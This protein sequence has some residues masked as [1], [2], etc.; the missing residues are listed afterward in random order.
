MDDK[1]FSE[2]MN[3]IREGSWWKR[4]DDDAVGVILEIRDDNSNNLIVRWT[5]PSFEGSRAGEYD[6]YEF[7]RKWVP[8]ESHPDDIPVKVDS[9]W[10]SNKT[11]DIVKVL[12][13]PDASYPSVHYI[14]LND[15][16]GDQMML[17]VDKTVFIT[18]H[19][20]LRDN[21]NG[22]L[23]RHNKNPNTYLKVIE[24]TKKP[25][26]MGAIDYVKYR[27]IKGD[28]IEDGHV[29]LIVT[30]HSCCHLLS[31]DPEKE[32]TVP[33]DSVRTIKAED[34]ETKR[35][36][37]KYHKIAKELRDLAKERDITIGSIW[38]G[39]KG[40]EEYNKG[41]LIKVVHITGNLISWRYLANA[42]G[43]HDIELNRYGTKTTCNSS[44]LYCFEKVQ[45]ND[46][47]AIY[48]P[49]DRVH[50][51]KENPGKYQM[52]KVVETNTSTTPGGSFICGTIKYITTPVS[53]SV[54][55][56]NL[57]DFHSE[58]ELVSLNPAEEFCVDV[59]DPNYSRKHIDPNK[60]ESKMD[61]SKETYLKTD[62]DKLEDF[63]TGAKREDKTGKGRYD[64]IPGDIMSE[65][66]DFAWTT[67]F[68]NGT[69]TCS[70]TDVSK[71]AYFDAWTNV[72]LYYDFMF[73]VVS[74]FFVPSID[75][76]ECEDDNGEVSYEITWDG[77]RAGLYNMR[78]ALAKHY[79]AGAVVHGVDNWKKGLPIYGSERGGCFLDSMR[80]HIDQALQGKDDEPH[81][82]AA[83]WNAFG[84]VW[85]LKNKST[86]T[87][88]SSE[89]KPEMDVKSKDC[90]GEF[91]TLPSG[92][93][94]RI[95]KF[96]KNESLHLMT[97]DERDISFLRGLHLNDDVIDS[98][99]ES[100]IIV[101]NAGDASKNMKADK[102][103]DKI[104]DAPTVSYSVLKANVSNCVE[105]LS[106]MLVDNKSTDLKFETHEAYINLYMICVFLNSV[107]SWFQENDKA[108]VCIEH[109]ISGIYNLINTNISSVR[110][111]FDNV[112]AEWV[113]CYDEEKYM[114]CLGEPDKYTV[115]GMIDLCCRTGMKL[116]NDDHFCGRA[117]SNG[118]LFDL[119]EHLSKLVKE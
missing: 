113:E 19:T 57:E 49:F 7:A 89:T 16:T 63:G 82:I 119:K 52:V 78:N 90:E 29:C 12:I 114:V 65:F 6:R 105:L 42:E 75:R 22:A 94:M 70:S 1:T 84:A 55:S 72:E 98:I 86:S 14:N 30:F 32:W 103:S 106:K 3:L 76:E 50:D 36:K 108:R 115:L 81:A 101:N 58:F 68:K 118:L 38:R 74:L 43:C 25:T 59:N 116:M 80:R 4:I 8:L 37:S 67:Y 51:A 18:E 41:R 99:M 60:G 11:G 83:L 62:K 23:Y 77:F 54:Y 13:E 102:A 34:E 109:L 56:V 85:T 96:L 107:L 46:D 87:T 28:S 104:A 20:F 45:D 15:T 117:I 24:T 73:N 48:Q 95:P 53:S 47:G 9:I 31:L 35:L 111:I 39:V 44:F 64:L 110:R 71:S 91:L 92:R 79:E 26:V 88:N 100:L 40:M 2:R 17:R 93:K 5:H 69:T 97:D 66:E 21:D 10:I 61:N 112:K 33:K 27:V